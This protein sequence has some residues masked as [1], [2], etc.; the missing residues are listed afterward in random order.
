MVFQ[1]GM[2]ARTG[3]SINEEV[4]AGSGEIRNGR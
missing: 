1:R 3:I 2:V 4:H